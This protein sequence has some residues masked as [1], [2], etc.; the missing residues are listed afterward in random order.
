M[1]SYALS[2]DPQLAEHRYRRR[3][4]VTGLGTVTPLGNDVTATWAAVRAGISGIG[5]LTKVNLPGLPVRV[6]GEITSFDPGAIADRKERRFLDDFC[7]FALAATAEAVADAGW[8]DAPPQRDRTAVI[9]GTGYGGLGAFERG[10]EILRTRGAGRVGPHVIPA[11]MANAAAAHLA[12][13]FQLRGPNQTVMTAC[14]AGAHAIGTAFRMVSSGEADAAIAG[15]AE[16][17]ICASALAGFAAMGA[18]S[19]RTTPNASRPFD[20]QRDGFVLAEG[21]GMLALEPLDAAC[22]RG[23]HIYGEI[24]GFAATADAYHVCAP[25]ADGVG[26]ARAMATA[27]DDAGLTP[28]DVDYVNAHGTSTRY[29]DAVETRAIRAVFGAHADRLLVSATK[30]MLG[31]MVG[32]AGA[33]E[34]I[35]TLLTLAE[36]IVVPTINLETPD[37]ECNLDYVA[38]QARLRP[39]AVAVKNSFGFGGANACLVFRRYDP[40]RT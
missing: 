23:A 3:V 20:A 33:V 14:A 1:H 12:Q 34:S 15:G 6:A 40:E 8:D 30:S 21:A 32:A 17:P 35:V 2:M 13:R 5:P 22:A 4:V 31:H 18:L 7:L 27:L 36:G 25:S 26:A 9:V 19:T 37:P 24:V 16:A 10:Y 29:N 11:G 39:I 28:S 38:N